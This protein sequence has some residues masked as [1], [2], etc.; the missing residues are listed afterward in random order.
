MHS[1]KS[2]AYVLV[3][4]AVISGMA[5]APTANAVNPYGGPCDVAED[6]NYQSQNWNTLCNMHIQMIDSCC[7]AGG[8]STY[9]C[10]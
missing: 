3:L 8:C 7:Q 5:N 6:L 10:G 1:K 2:L 9:P 4:L